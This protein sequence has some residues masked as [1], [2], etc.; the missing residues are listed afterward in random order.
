MK[1]KRV[2]ERTGPADR[3]RFVGFSSI[4]RQKLI[5][6]TGTG[7]PAAACPLGD[8]RGRVTNASGR[9]GQASRRSWAGTLLLNVN[10]TTKI[11]GVR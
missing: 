6:A 11:L 8:T 4:A 9:R 7:L 2:C 5:T 3:R 1:F 10:N